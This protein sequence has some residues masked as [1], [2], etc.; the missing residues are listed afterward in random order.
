MTDQFPLP[1]QSPFQPGPDQGAGFLPYAQLVNPPH[2]RFGVASFIL[3]IAVGL[4]ELA[5]LALATALV[6]RKNASQGPLMIT[7]GCG[8]FLGLAVALVGLVLG[9]I[10]TRQTNRRKVFAILGTCFNGIILLGVLALLILGS[11]R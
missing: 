4:L 8:M 1:E 5:S 3:A 11:M 6:F 9:I 2:S 7:A 10:G